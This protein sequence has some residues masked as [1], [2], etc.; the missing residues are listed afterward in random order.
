PGF[1]NTRCAAGDGLDFR[2][3]DST[4][5]RLDRH[6]YV[7][8]SLRSIAAGYYLHLLQ[9]GPTPRQHPIATATARRFHEKCAPISPTRHSNQIGIPSV[10]LDG[11]QPSSTRSYKGHDGGH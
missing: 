3:S 7:G 5:T 11:V 4:G 6:D 1:F 2:L 9:L 8:P 10:A